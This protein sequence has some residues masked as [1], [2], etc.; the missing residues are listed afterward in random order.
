M[1]A[2]RSREDSFTRPQSLHMIQCWDVFV[3]VFYQPLK[4]VVGLAWFNSKGA[5]YIHIFTYL[6]NLSMYPGYFNVFNVSEFRHGISRH[7]EHRR[8]AS[9]IP[10]CL[11]LH[12]ATNQ[13]RS[14]YAQAFRLSC[15]LNS[16]DI[17]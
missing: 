7:H 8:E 4:S 16:L 3:Q 10:V 1:E 17:E 5:S 13:S 11:F 2:S 6:L 12:C 14:I 9:K 15:G